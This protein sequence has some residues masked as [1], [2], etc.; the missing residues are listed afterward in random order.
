[1]TI[2]F[3]S[4]SFTTSL[5]FSLPLSF[6]L[7]V[8]FTTSQPH[9]H[10]DPYLAE[11]LSH[12]QGVLSV[13]NISDVTLSS[14]DASVCCIHLTICCLLSLGIAPNVACDN[15]AFQPQNT[16]TGVLRG[17]LPLMH[18]HT[19]RVISPLPCSGTQVYLGQSHP[20]LLSCKSLVNL[21]LTIPSNSDLD[22]LCQLY[23]VHCTTVP[24]HQA[25]V[26]S[27]T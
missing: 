2:F 15:Q 25:P 1:M 23:A 27:L 8:S 21:V 4:L 22:T 20:S 12:Q 16:V 24:R 3:S 19:V 7:A 14:G 26:W 5:C 18:L 13:F 9:S 6:S 10:S 11:D 17:A